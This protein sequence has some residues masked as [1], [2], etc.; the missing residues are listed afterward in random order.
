MRVFRGIEVRSTRYQGKPLGRLLDKFNFEKKLLWRAN[1][2]NDKMAIWATDRPFSQSGISPIHRPTICKWLT[3]FHSHHYLFF[4]TTP[5]QVATTSNYTSFL[6]YI[7]PSPPMI[8]LVFL[9]LK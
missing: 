4:T 9:Y 3:D 5:I 1:F 2:A 8:L 7:F 6:L